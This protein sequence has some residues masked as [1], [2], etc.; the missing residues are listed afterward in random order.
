MGG[1]PLS[2]NSLKFEVFPDFQIFSNSWG[3]LDIA[4]LLVIIKHASFHLWWKENLVKHQNVSKYH[5]QDCRFPKFLKLWLTWPKSITKAF[6]FQDSFNPYSPMMEFF[7]KILLSEEIFIKM[8]I[9]GFIFEKKN[10]KIWS[11]N[12]KLSFRQF[13][14]TLVEGGY[15]YFFKKNV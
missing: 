9:F 1:W 8:N 11:K 4:C 13:K 7:Y 2:Y 12:P 6:P 3:N 15:R 10:K 5:D 14:L